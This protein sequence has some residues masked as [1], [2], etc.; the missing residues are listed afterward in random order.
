[1]SDTDQSAAGTVTDPAASV[2]DSQRSGLS[3]PQRSIAAL[4]AIVLASQ[5]LV[6]LLTLV[7]LRMLRVDQPGLATTLMLVLM[8]ACIGVAGVIRRGS[9][10]WHAGT[11]IQVVLLACGLIH[12]SLAGLGVIFG[13]TW[14]Y[15]L[16]VRRK[17][18]KPPVR[19]GD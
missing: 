14:L 19:T 11:A 5:A 16:S 9:W 1:M 7:P 17:L 18:S 3:D 4:G 2:D 12:W 10:A 13:L 15:A 8:V 6:L